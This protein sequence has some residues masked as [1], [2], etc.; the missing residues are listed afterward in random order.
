MISL[1]PRTNRPAHSRG[2]L[3]LIC[4]LL[5]ASPA[6]AGPGAKPEDIVAQHL[7]AIATPEARAAVKSR[8]V[9][10]SLRFKVTRGG[11]GESPGVWQLLS[12]E[13]RSKFVMKFGDNHWWG[14][15]FVSDGDRASFATATLSHTWSPLGAFVKGQDFIVKDGLLGGELGVGWVLDHLDRHHVR[16]EYAGIQKTDGRGLQVIEYVS[17]DNGNMIVKF[18]FEPETHHHVMTVYSLL[19]DAIIAHND[20]DNA[21]QFSD[22]RTLEE[23]FGDFQTDNG[24]TLPRKYGLR[25]IQLLQDG[26][27]E[28]YDWDLSVDKIV[29]NPILAPS[30]F[31]VK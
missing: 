29:E 2:Y 7:Q 9:Q 26:T 4:V 1:P 5:A 28:V 11:A 23:R 3:S 30:N 21:H 14:E 17:K 20:I 31:Q 16:L 15:Q 12:E 27:T 22:R 25:Y 13:R 6:G 19:R 8:A 10:G 18:Y 24:T